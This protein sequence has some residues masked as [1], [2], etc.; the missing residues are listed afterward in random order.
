MVNECKPTRLALF[1][2]RHSSDN[3][4][5]LVCNAGL[6]RAVFVSPNISS[7]FFF[8]L[9]VRLLFQAT[10][11]CLFTCA[12]SGVGP[13]FVFFLSHY[14]LWRVKLSILRLAYIRLAS[15]KIDFCV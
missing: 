11:A 14:V 4:H 15:R 7:F 1:L 2:G 9:D 8:Q 3:L 6:G 10:I 13:V 5:D 12:G